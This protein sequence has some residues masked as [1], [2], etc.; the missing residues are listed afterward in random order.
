MVLNLAEVFRCFLYADRTSVPL[1][2]ELQ[3]IRAY[4]QI[5]ALRLGEKL[6][7]EISVDQSAKKALIPVLSVQPLIENA[8]KHGA[9]N[10][11][12]PGIVRLNA[13]TTQEGVRIEV[14]DDGEGVQSSTHGRGSPSGRAVGLDNVRQRLRLRFGES[15]RVRIESSDQG[16]TVSL[17]APAAT[18][19]PSIPK[20]AAV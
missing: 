9:A 1:A 16:S 10:R 3:F 11:S 15:A 17:L 6:K 2:E 14:S 20:E 19:V 12:G 4:L 7:T 13:W 8:V 5:E 18:T